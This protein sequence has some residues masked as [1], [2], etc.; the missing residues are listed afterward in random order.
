MTIISLKIKWSTSRGRDT[1]GYNI[2]R[3]VDTDTGKHYR[4]IGGGYDM[5]GK[6][7][8][9]WL[10][11]VYQDRLK[12]LM[13]SRANSKGVFYGLSLNEKTGVY[14]VDGR[15]GTD[16]VRTIMTAVDL[17]SKVV[18]IKNSLDSFLI[19]DT[20]EQIA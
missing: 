2:C 16:S 1:Y 13:P 5:T 18:C 6:V 15:C 4:T 11:E 14:H 3:L 8:G 12:E 19:E 10:S 17:E 7:L 20:R 9:D